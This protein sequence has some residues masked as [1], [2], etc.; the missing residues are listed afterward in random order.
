MDK[1]FCVDLD[2][3]FIKTDMLIESFAYHFFRNP[4]IVFLCLFWLIKG[5][6]VL[7]KH[8][9]SIKYNFDAKDIPVND[10]V[11]NLIKEKKSNGYKT[12]L[13]SASIKNIVE[14]FYVAYQNIFD[15]YYSS[16]I[17][18]VNLS[19]RNKA[20]LLNKIFG[21]KNYEYIGNSSDDIEVWNNSS[22]SYCFF[23]SEKLKSKFCTEG[24]E[25]VNICNKLNNR[26]GGGDKKYYKTIK[27]LS[28]G[29]KF[30][31]FS[32]CSCL[33]TFAID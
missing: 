15:G 26:W 8:N 3:T 23:K 33:W 17:G 5:G 10:E 1:I 28:M 11:L 13:V 30:S 29:K 25:I 24:L 2:G 32:S 22:V 7:L 19:S 12:Y 6:K 27:M 20:S 9:L 16:E 21:K 18:N 4:L 31:Y 14:K